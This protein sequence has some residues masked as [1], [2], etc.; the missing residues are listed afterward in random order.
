MAS[1]W[2]TIAALTGIAS[3]ILFVMGLAIFEMW[4]P[5]SDV[6][7]I[8][9]AALTTFGVMTAAVSVGTYLLSQRD[10]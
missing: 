3:F 5:A 2:F 8:S 10:G 1:W 7:N 6:Y 4:I 9:S